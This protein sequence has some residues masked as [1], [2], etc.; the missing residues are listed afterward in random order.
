MIIETKIGPKVMFTSKINIE[1]RLVNGLV[2]E[3]MNIGHE[4]GAV[5]VIYVKF[6]NQNDGLVTN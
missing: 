3:I 1:K 2:G 6:N 5:T 4:Q